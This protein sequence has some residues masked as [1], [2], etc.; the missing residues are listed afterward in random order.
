MKSYV[1]I[2]HIRAC[3]VNATSCPYIAGF[4][5]MTG[6]MGLTHSIERRLKDRYDVTITEMGVCCHSFKL[7]AKREKGDILYSPVLSRNP[8]DVKPMGECTVAPFIEGMEAWLDV[9]LVM[10]IEGLDPDDDRAVARA[11]HE[12][13]LSLR[14]CGGIAESCEE[15]VFFYPDED[16]EDDE[17]K[18]FHRLGAGSIIISRTDLLQELSAQ[19]GTDALD[20]I[21]KALAVHQITSENT[22]THEKKYQRYKQISSG[23]LVP[24]AVGYR[25]ISP[26]ATIPGQRDMSKPHRFVESVLTLAE[27]KAPWHFKSLEE[28]M[29][30]YEYNESQG[31]YLVCQN[32]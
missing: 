8:L 21:L 29:W 12:A 20:G 3:G 13:V 28:M 17:A 30:H 7:H 27:F 2:P 16:N 10:R 25:A 5:S 18:F 31:T 23:W 26:L 32:K 1:R 14:I 22:E 24:M 6:W 15:P 11:L 9:T 4:P 19:E